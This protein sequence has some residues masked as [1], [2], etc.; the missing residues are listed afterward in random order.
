VNYNEGDTVDR[1][2]YINTR[3]IWA[4]ENN[5][6]LKLAAEIREAVH[7][8]PPTA[9]EWKVVVDSPYHKVDLMLASD[10]DA[11]WVLHGQILTSAKFANTLILYRAWPDHDHY[12]YGTTMIPLQ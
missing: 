8:E 5:G 2:K 1:T 11:R 7:D 4:I 10:T 12:S 3:A 9:S 6:D